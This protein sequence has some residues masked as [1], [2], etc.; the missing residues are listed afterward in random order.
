LHVLLAEAHRR[1]NRLEES[2]NEYKKA[3]RIHTRLPLDY[4]CDACGETV[5]E[6]Q[7]RCPECGTWGSFSMVGR[8]LIQS[9]R[10]VEL[11]PIHH[12]E[13]EAWDEE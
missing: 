13:R 12:G 8:K 3:L 9:A 10:A 2:I 11:R 5:A 7:S 1:R 4:V 6:W